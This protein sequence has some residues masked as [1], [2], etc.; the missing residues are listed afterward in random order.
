MPA[1]KNFKDLPPERRVLAGVVLAVG[2]VLVAAAERDL[3]RRGQDEVKGPKLLWRLASLNAL[4]AIG[5]FKFGRRKARPD[6][7]PPA[8]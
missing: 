6:S 5:Y 3:Q 8:A 1:V 2:L 4:G 7:A